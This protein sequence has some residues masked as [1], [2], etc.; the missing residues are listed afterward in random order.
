MR[1]SGI[2]YRISGLRT[3]IFALFFL[4]AAAL[5]VFST[6]PFAAGSLFAGEQLFDDE[7]TTEELKKGHFFYMIDEQGRTVL[8][9]GRR[10]RV[11]DRFLN[12]ANELYEVVSVDGYLARARF[13]EK[14]KLTQP[15]VRD[16]GVGEILPVQKE[17]QPAYKIAI[18]H[19]HNAESYVPSDGTDSIY[20]TGGIHDVGRA[21]KEALEKKGVNVLYS[22][23]LHLPHDR[24]AYRRSRVTALRLIKERPDAIFDLHRD[25]APWEKYAIEIGGETITQIQI[26]VGLSNPGASTNEQ[27]AYDLKGYADRIYP[28]LIH[29]VLL[30][31]GSYNQDISPLALLLEVGAH[32]NTKEAA[33]RG[34][35]RFAGVVSYYF[36]GPAFLKDKSIG[37]GPQPPKAAPANRSQYGI[38]R[39]FSGTILSLLLISVGAAVGFYFLNNPGALVEIYRWWEG[40]PGK[41]A[42]LEKRIRAS[43]RELPLLLKSVRRAAPFNLRLGW[44]KLRREGPAVPR[45]FRKLGSH[46]RQF[47]RWF[48]EGAAHLYREAPLNLRRAGQRLR[49]E[50]RELPRRIGGGLGGMKEKGGGFRRRVSL[51]GQELR[52]RLGLAWR[53]AGSEAAALS[54]KI[55][56]YIALLRDRL[57][58]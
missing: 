31:W 30:I 3:V 28:G 44:Q 17:V 1:V 20:G 18:Y 51:K 11:K 2:N 58:L 34:I 47:G 53:E 41:A 23:Q 9:T 57:R 45:L 33:E 39:A 14:V 25:A 15:A 54:G 13:V 21:F 43:W 56:E 49:R 24:G 38:M 48:L 26:V 50:G 37:P 46:L 10:L 7:L 12:A 29:G 32:T 5:P 4:A 40:L 42:A 16:I 35:A 6:G 22:D 36:Y 55:R 27:F 19:S 8:T 52:E